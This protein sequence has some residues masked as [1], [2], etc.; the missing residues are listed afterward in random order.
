MIQYISYAD[1]NEFYRIKEVC[2]LLEMDKENLRKSC[3]KYGVRPSRNEMGDW[4]VNLSRP[5]PTAQLLVQRGKEHGYEKG[6]RSVGVIE[7]LTVAETAALL[8]TTKQQVRKMI[9]Q[10]LIPALKIGREWR[11]SRQYL[12]D[13]LRNNMI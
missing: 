4:G 8:K 5:A 3:E 11:I 6:R 7:L 13:F 12:E 10:Q 1:L 2:R 9:A